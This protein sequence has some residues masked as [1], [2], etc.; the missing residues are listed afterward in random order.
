MTSEMW[1][2]KLYVGGRK[3]NVGGMYM[4]NGNSKKN[5]PFGK[6]GLHVERK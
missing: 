6:R 3:D 5:F 4:D 2:S 1:C